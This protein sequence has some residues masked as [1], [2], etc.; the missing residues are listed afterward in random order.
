[1]PRSDYRNRGLTRE[2]TSLPGAATADDRLRT[3]VGDGVPLTPEDGEV[4][5]VVALEFVGEE[6]EG[7]LDQAS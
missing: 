6:D 5:A 3:V 4:L 7:A 1:L 2:W